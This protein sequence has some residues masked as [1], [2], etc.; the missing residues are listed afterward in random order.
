[1]RLVRVWKDMRQQVI[2]MAV[3]S[4]WGYVAVLLENPEG[5]AVWIAEMPQWL[6]CKSY[7][8]F[9][10]IACRCFTVTSLPGPS[11]SKVVDAARL[12]FCQNSHDHAFLAV[13]KSAQVRSTA[14]GKRTCSSAPTHHG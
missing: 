1:M 5:S 3:N 6:G 13:V 7:C 10:S 2:A 14:H 9:L 12:S 4:D 11:H 8:Q